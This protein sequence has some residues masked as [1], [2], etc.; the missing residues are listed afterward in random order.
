MSVEVIRVYV[1]PSETCDNYYGSSSM[2]KLEEQWNKDIKSQHTTKRSQCPVCKSERE[3]RFAKII[4]A[5]EVAE[6]RARV[7]REMAAST[8]PPPTGGPM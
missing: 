2:G 7:Q 6:V 5:S 1:C 3:E 8:S 4:P